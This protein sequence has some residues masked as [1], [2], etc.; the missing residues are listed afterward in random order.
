MKPSVWGATS[1]FLIK[2]W[3]CEQRRARN[4]YEYRES[5]RNSWLSI[6]Y[7]LDIAFSRAET[8]EQRVFC[9]WLCVWHG[10]ARSHMSRECENKVLKCCDLDAN[11]RLFSREIASNYARNNK[12]L[13]LRLKNVGCSRVKSSFNNFLHGDRSQTN[14]ME[15]SKLKISWDQPVSISMPIFSINI[16]ASSY[17]SIFPWLIAELEL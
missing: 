16:V 11:S 1:G 17:F 2:F 8:A 5:K 9:D 4:L 14:L 7:I 6:R 3:R 12:Q 13:G 10:A 15:I